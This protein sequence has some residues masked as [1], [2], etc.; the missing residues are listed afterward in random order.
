MTFG[1]L[2]EL[3]SFMFCTLQLTDGTEAIDL[4]IELVLLQDD[5]LDVFFN[6][7]DDSEIEELEDTGVNLGYLI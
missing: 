3:Q 2:S 5:F 6:E 7:F 4:V 1:P